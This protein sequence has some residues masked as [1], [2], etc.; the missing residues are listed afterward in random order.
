MQRTW[1]CLTC[2][3]NYVSLKKLLLFSLFILYIGRHK[4]DHNVH[5]KLQSNNNSALL[6][7]PVEPAQSLL[8]SLSGE[9]STTQALRLTHRLDFRLIVV[10]G[11]AI[12]EKESKYE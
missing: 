12:A 1:V 11:G 3:S 7:A 10:L 4:Q 8:Y 6:V 5:L 2:S 9:E